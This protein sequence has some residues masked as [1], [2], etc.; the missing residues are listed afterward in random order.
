MR[1][2]GRAR[3]AFS[4][5][6]AAAA[7]AAALGGCGSGEVRD[8]SRGGPYDACDPDGDGSDC[9]LST[10]GCAGVAVD[11]VDYRTELRGLCSSV[12]A[13][14]ADCPADPPGAG[15]ACL[16]FDGDVTFLCYER[17]ARDEDCPPAFA[18]T[19]RLPAAGGGDFFFD[20]I[21]LPVR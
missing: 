17:C 18:C 15:G 12:C 6:F 8:E 19:D 20:P 7:L 4:F 16:S 9:P 11:Y 14:D 21:C 1:E 3:G 10:D 13:S 5:F 2:H